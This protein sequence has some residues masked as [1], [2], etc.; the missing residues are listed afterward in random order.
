[1][2]F[3]LVITPVALIETAM[4]RGQ[5]ITVAAIANILIY[6]LLVMGSIAVHEAGHAVVARA[7]GLHVLRVELGIG[8][9]VVRWRRGELRLQLNRFPILGLTYLG[10]GSR[11]L[12][13]WR[14]WLAILGGPVTTLAILAAALGAG[15]LR[16]QDVLWPSGP[17]AG[18]IAIAHLLAF[19]N[20]WMLARNLVPLNLLGHRTDGRQLLTIPFAAQ[21]DLEQLRL[22]RP[23]LDFAEHLEDRAFD[24]AERALDDVRQIVRDSVFVRC[25][26]ATL[27]Q[28][29][30]RHAE[31]RELFLAL[32][33]DPELPT[34]LRW[35]VL[36]NLAWA[37]YMLY[38]PSLRDEADRYSR[39]ALAAAKSSPHAMETRAA[40]LGWSGRHEEALP[41]L[42]RAFARH[43]SL[44][45]RA[46]VACSLAISWV[47]YDVDVAE[48]WLRR[49]R[50]EDPA[51]ELLHRAEAAIASAR[52]RIAER[53]ATDAAV[54]DPAA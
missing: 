16:V 52:A 27:V 14:P 34:T 21:R 6:P 41:L 43:S 25:N 40:V 48:R 36:N 49:A 32:A 30:G 4:V 9:R 45:A 8:R 24:A 31:A 42:D 5:A 26:A 17:V 37:N 35:F 53:D 22:V 50:K 15:R 11:P 33:A 51:C 19:Q 44:I 38:D 7:V 47:T 28:L 3:G 23:M 10:A 29:R 12:Q 1:M 39:E 18:G 54:S 13:R 20:L 2:I 46:S